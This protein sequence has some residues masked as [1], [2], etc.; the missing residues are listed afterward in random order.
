MVALSTPKTPATL[1]QAMRHFTPEVSAAYVQSI[2]W[3]DG[4]CCPKCG[5]MNVGTIPARVRFQCREKGCRKQFSLTTGTIFEATHLKL[6][7]WL[8]AAWMVVNCRNGVSSCEIARTIGC[9][10]QSAWHLLHRL[11]HILTPEV[12]GMLSGEVEA[13]E[14][15]VGGL[16]KFM[17][18]SRRRRAEQNGRPNGKSVVHA[19]KERGSG[20]VRAEVIPAARV[21][22]VR[23]AVMENVEEGSKLYTDS[24]SIYKWAGDVYQHSTVNHAEEYVRGDCHTNGLENYFNCLRRGLKGTYIKAHHE[25]LSAY[26]NEQTFRFN[27]RTLTDWERFEC[28]MQ[29]IVGK[30]L[31]YTTLTDGAER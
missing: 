24:A 13:D 19:M 2:K 1:M 17:S 12:S 5:S 28:A 27:H 18:E 22:F 31:T 11:R 3:P 10:Q 15:F 7:Q 14:T 4:P 8:I 6:D 16:F 30:R 29:K 20:L 23:D 9:K 21:E 25:H 26:V